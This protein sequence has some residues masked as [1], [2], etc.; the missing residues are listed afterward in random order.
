MFT[1]MGKNE[2]ALAEADV[3]VYDAIASRPREKQKHQRYIGFYWESPAIHKMLMSQNYMSIYDFEYS[4]RM[5]ADLVD[6][7]SIVEIV[8]SFEHIATWDV[9]PFSVKKKNVMIT[10][11]IS[12]CDVTTNGRIP[13]L[14]QL[15]SLG[16]S[17]RNFGRCALKGGSSLSQYHDL[18]WESRSP[19]YSALKNKSL[20][21]IGATK[22][23]FENLYEG[24]VSLFYYA[25]ENSNCEYYHTEKA[26]VAL[27]SGAIP[28][29]LGSNVT[30]RDYFPENSMI[31]LADFNSTEDLARHLVS[32]SHNESAYNKYL[33]WR[34][35]P[36]AHHLKSKIDFALKHRNEGQWC[37]VCES[38]HRQFNRRGRVSRVQDPK[39]CN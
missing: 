18:A 26:W 36:L 29:Y 37:Y 5:K 9:V 8:G 30:A 7:S 35:L 15:I 6:L 31:Y 16:V 22:I 20:A 3:V 14:E 39:F 25:A 23:P 11:W 34:K 13:R 19:N 4:Y 21:I 27:N 33:E 1:G 17:A 28:I 38:L 2:S 32:L 12:N 24:G 10:S